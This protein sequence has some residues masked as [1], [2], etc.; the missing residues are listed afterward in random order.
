MACLFTLLAK[1]ESDQKAYGGA[2]EG[3][4]LV[5]LSRIRLRRATSH[6]VPNQA[7]SSENVGSG[8]VHNE[9][10]TSWYIDISDCD[11][12]CEYCGARF[13]YGELLKGYYKN[14]KVEYR[15]CCWIVVSYG[16]MFQSIVVICGY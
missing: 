11:C 8:S 3:V 7:M 16:D 14:R 6:S 4:P 1:K 15:K 12:S 2:K 10:I 5:I 9:A 13:W